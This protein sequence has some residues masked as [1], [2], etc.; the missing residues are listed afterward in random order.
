MR[1]QVIE[2]TLPV[3]LSFS[4]GFQNWLVFSPLTL[5]LEMRSVSTVMASEL[6]KPANLKM[7]TGFLLACDFLADS[8]VL[9]DR[10]L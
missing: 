10:L 8:L 3:V 2:V 1:E 9:V 6:A 4:T 7:T 5:L